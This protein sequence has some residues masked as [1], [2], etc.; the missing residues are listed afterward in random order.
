M[1][2]QGMLVPYPRGWLPQIHQGPA[3]AVFQPAKLSLL[4]HRLVLSIPSANSMNR[5]ADWLIRDSV[6][7]DSKQSQSTFCKS[8]RQ[9]GPDK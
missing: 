7:T 9:H 1:F 5:D 2:V 3:F 6:E 8:N 4:G